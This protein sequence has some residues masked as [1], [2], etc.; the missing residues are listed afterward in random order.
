MKIDNEEDLIKIIQNNNIDKVKEIFNRNRIESK[1]LNYFHET[2]YF[3]IKE[4]YSL[5]IIIFFIEQQTVFYKYQNIDNTN[6][7]YY[8]IENSN[9]KVAKLLLRKG[10]RIDNKENN[11]LEYLFKKR[12]LDSEKLL[13]ILNIVKDTSLCTLTIKKREVNSDTTK[14]DNIEINTNK[15]KYNKNTNIDD[16]SY[17]RDTNYNIKEILYY[18]YCEIPNSANL[19][20]ELEDIKDVENINVLNEKIKNIINNFFKYDDNGNNN[21]SNDINKKIKSIQD[22]FRNKIVDMLEDRIVN[23]LKF[24]YGKEYRDEDLK[25]FITSSEYKVFIESNIDEILNTAFID[26]TKEGILNNGFIEKIND[27]LSLKNG[28]K[29]NFSEIEKV[30]ISIQKDYGIYVENDDTNKQRINK[31][32]YNILFNNYGEL[33]EK[34]RNDSLLKNYLGENESFKMIFYKTFVENLKNK[35]YEPNFDIYNEINNKNS[36]KEIKDKIGEVIKSTLTDENENEN[37][38][39]LLLIKKKIIVERMLLDTIKNLKLDDETVKKI[40][41]SFYDNSKNFVISN[42]KED[43]EKIK[44]KLNLKLQGFKVNT[45]VNFDNQIKN[46]LKNSK[47]ENNDIQSLINQIKNDSGNYILN[48]TKVKEQFNKDLVESFCEK[49]SNNSKYKSEVIEEIIKN[50]RTSKDIVSRKA[51]NDLIDSIKYIKTNR[52]NKKTIED[53]QTYINV[54]FE[55]LLKVTKFEPTKQYIDRYMD[56]LINNLLTL[57]LTNGKLSEQVG[58]KVEDLFRE[59]KL[60][61][62]N[63]NEYK[64]YDD[65]IKKINYNIDDLAESILVK[66]RNRINK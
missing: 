14:I 60:K 13:F 38:K 62:I 47:I 54:I 50:N 7:L 33:K 20:N 16:L 11:V 27:I 48:E 59:D 43:I 44:S 49:L 1:N 40:Y 30:I 29:V 8:S 37:K 64:N 36:E 26:N 34:K 39:T 17:E 25:E 42:S 31:I 53:S 24:R 5:E 55:E 63:N 52:K 22:G 61:H 58:N 51:I 12:K 15:L 18:K 19:V 57:K 2:L 35:L 32:L 28:E 10:V 21:N 41:D 6:L 56:N 46:I 45:E 66:N 3:L 23:E 65:F 9:F 4:N